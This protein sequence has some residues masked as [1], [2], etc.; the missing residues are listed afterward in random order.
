[1]ARPLY[2]NAV[3]VNRDS[4]EMPDRDPRLQPKVLQVLLILAERSPDIV[5]KRE[6]FERVWSNVSVSE[7]VLSQAIAELRR[8]FGE[9][10]VRTIPRV[11]Y[12]L[13]ATVSEKPDYPAF[14]PSTAGVSPPAE[15]GRRHRM[16]AGLK[17]WRVAFLIVLVAIIVNMLVMHL[18]GHGHH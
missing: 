13:E 1:M 16:G 14:A 12:K 3:L 2:V 4:G 15:T 17:F 18:T 6:L 11:G 8:V 7:N 5:T 9:S 10:S